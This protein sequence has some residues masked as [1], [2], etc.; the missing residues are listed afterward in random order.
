MVLPSAPG[1]VDTKPLIH[2][3]EG[4]EPYRTVAC[5]LWDV[6]DAGTSTI[7]TSQSARG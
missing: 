3:V 1:Y 6:L 2:H 5:P 4:I 7:L